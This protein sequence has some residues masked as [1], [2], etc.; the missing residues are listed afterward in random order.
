MGMYRFRQGIE[1][2]Y[3]VGVVTLSPKINTN[4][5]N[6]ISAF[7]KSFARAFAPAMAMAA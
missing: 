2:Y 5:K 4:A 1:R 3:C 6:K 7:R